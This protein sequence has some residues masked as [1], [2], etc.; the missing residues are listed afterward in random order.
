MN[1]I[2]TDAQNNSLSCGVS[3]RKGLYFEV[4]GMSQKGADTAG[5]LAICTVAL[6]AGSY[7]MRRII[8]V[9]I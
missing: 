7:V 2:T 5:I 6:L 1:Q 4:N 3:T 9:S 8:K